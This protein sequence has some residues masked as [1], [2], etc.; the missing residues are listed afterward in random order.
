MSAERDELV[1]VV[2]RAVGDRSAARMV[3]DI[4]SAYDPA[5]WDVLHSI[6]VWSLGLPPEMGGAGGGLDEQLACAEVLGSLAVPVPSTSVWVA[7]AVLATL[8]P[9]PELLQIFSEGKEPVGVLLP[10][11]TDAVVTLEVDGGQLS[12]AVHGAIDG[13]S[14]CHAIVAAAGRWW[15]IDLRTPTVTVTM[16]SAFDHTRPTADVQFASTPAVEL[17]EVDPA[18]AGADQVTALARALLAADALGAGRA[19]LELAVQYS[20]D[21]HAFGHPIGSYQAVKHQLADMLVAVETSAS[22]VA[23]TAWSAVEG[24]PDATAALI[25]KSTACAAGM[26]ATRKS[27]QIHGAIACTWEHD[28]HLLMRRAK[29]DELVL[30]SPGTLL[31]ELGASLVADGAAGTR[32]GRSPARPLFAVDAADQAFLDELRTWLA[33]ELTDDWRA[34]WRDR[35]AGARRRAF[36]EWQGFMADAGWV[37]IHWPVEHGGRDATL[38]QQVMYHAELAGQNVPGFIGNR[39]LSLTGPTL[40]VH[41]TP[42]QRQRFVEATR[43]A[44]ILWASG[45][46]ERDAGSDLAALSTRAVLDGDEF[47]VNGHKIWTTNAQFCE[48]M[49]TLVRTGPL[50]P[51]HDGI[52]VLLIPLD[53]PGVTVQPIRRNAGDHHFNEVFLDDARVSATNLVGPLNGGWSVARTTLS[54]EHLTNFLG[55]Q[56]RQSKV[57]E[58]IIERARDRGR[59]GQPIDASLRRRIAESWVNSEVLRLHG[60]RNVTRTQA[61]RDPGPEGSIVKLFGQEEEQRL[62]E[63]A[64]DVAGVS[65]LRED[66]WALSFMST[67]ASTIGGGTS[68][69][70]RNKIAERVLGMPR[71][72][73][74]EPSKSSSPTG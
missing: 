29:F 54:H 41:G 60:M 68:E 25:A 26:L 42:E 24:F 19:A 61:G 11:D 9:P 43:R 32:S 12:G 64:I 27:T 51:K 67:R 52:S 23:G 2:R 57:V 45:L 31:D 40:I 53:A 33:A 73:S 15:W 66:S 8:A 62:Y 10:A 69:I 20:L 28:L 55:A 44:D 6:G 38:A 63:L 14:L 70:H 30:S 65:S 59:R 49:F 58:R 74:S 22:A 71:D 37:G 21:R 48:W 16:Q 47:V 34:R 56:L 5:V 1:D 3:T 7:A 35:D 39:G 13:A 46:S 17:G 36:R 4:G 50:E 18:A 72:P